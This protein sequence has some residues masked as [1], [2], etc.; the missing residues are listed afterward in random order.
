M[1]LTSEDSIQIR[2]IVGD[3]FDRKI[4]P[5]IGELEAL[6]NDAKEIYGMLVDLNKRIGHTSIL[7]PRFA[8]LP[9][10]EQLLHL[11]DIIVSTAQRMGVELPR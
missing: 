2:D 10:K 5:I 9:D 8:E 7:D 6:R 3:V 11:N 4:D 1:S